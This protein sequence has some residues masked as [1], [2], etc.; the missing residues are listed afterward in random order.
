MLQREVALKL[1]RAGNQFAPAAGRAF[2]EEARRLAQVRHPNVLAVHGAAVHEGRAGI[3]TDLIMGETLAARVARDGAL[4]ANALLQL[5]SALSGALAA[6]HAKSIVHGDLT[7]MNVMCEASTQRFVLMDFG[8]GAS[9]DESGQTRL[10]AG[11]LHFMAPEQLSTD[12]LG[13][14]ADLYSLGATLFYAATRRTPDAPA[15]IQRLDARADLTK[16]LKKLI[17]ALVDPIPDARPTAAAIFEQCHELLAEPERAKRR[18]LRRASMGMLGIAIIAML[19]GLIFT[20]RAQTRATRAAERSNAALGFIADWFK[21]ADP[22][23]NNGQQLTAHAMFEHGAK[24]LRTELANQPAVRGR[25]EYI[26]GEGFLALGES[27]AALPNFEQA[28]GLLKADPSSDPLMLAAALERGAYAAESVSRIDQALLWLA[29]ADALTTA[30]TEQTVDLRVQILATRWLIQR[31]DGRWP[32]AFKLAERALA[33]SQRYDHGAISERSTRAL[34]RLGN[35]LK[36][37]GRLPEALAAMERGQ[38]SYE[39]LFGAGDMRTVNADEVVGW[40]LVDLG[41]LDEAEKKLDAVAKLVRASVGENS[42]RYANNVYDHAL[43]YVA[44]GQLP[45]ARAAFV[46][47]ARIYAESYAPN[48]VHRGWALQQAAEL[49]SKL[50]DHAQA[51]QKL[52]EVEHLWDGPMQPDSP[53]RAELWR[54][55][56]EAQ[57]AL[58]R[59]LEASE[60]VDKALVTLGAQPPGY[61]GGMAKA[62]SLKSAIELSRGHRDEALAL[63]ADAIATARRENP[64]SASALEDIAT[65]ERKQAELVH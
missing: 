34:I 63:I 51:L 14:A 45:R 10:G 3:W 35:S 18:K 62:L 42:R 27:G 7:P 21:V 29:E 30:D 65:Y 47:A 58:G 50:G 9:L 37:A 52:L 36:D 61:E 24:R 1:R 48:P 44:R 39:K 33:L 46:E 49:D 60:Y 19:L 38:A 64:P 23:F 59:S 31:S 5:L 32:E 43:L 15:A 55:I 6:V 16:P 17:R 8:G 11:S 20:T 12:R 13:T 28:I 40:V 26:I 54:S 53:I 56:G 25:M 22:Y 4:P 41:R 2:I 57:L